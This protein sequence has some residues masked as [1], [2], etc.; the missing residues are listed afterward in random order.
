VIIKELA[1]VG[2]DKKYSESG[3]TDPV[4]SAVTTGQKS[5]DASLTSS[6]IQWRKVLNKV[7]T[8]QARWDESKKLV[9]EANQP[10]FSDNSNLRSQLASSVQKLGVQP[11]KRML[12][13][14]RE[15]PT[16]NRSHFGEENTTLYQ[17]PTL[18]Q[19]QRKLMELRTALSS[20]VRQSDSDSD[21]RLSEHNSVNDMV[22]E[23]IHLLS[24]CAI[25]DLHPSSQKEQD[26][27]QSATSLLSLAE[28][29]SLFAVGLV[30]ELVDDLTK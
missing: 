24:V 21:F 19:L 15:L 12:Y 30:A 27:S 14:N 6:S 9:Q 29:V 22:H 25:P 4:P 26:R 18:N 8:L 11:T 2:V 1:G 10:Q 23:T 16:P 20:Y 5:G 17:Q 28:H 3:D 13:G 7:E